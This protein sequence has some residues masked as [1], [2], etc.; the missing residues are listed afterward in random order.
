MGIPP[1]G[2]KGG[3]HFK[4]KGGFLVPGPIFLG[5]KKSRRKKEKGVPKKG[6]NSGKRKE[7]PRKF[8]ENVERKGKLTGASLTV[9]KRVGGMPEKETEFFGSSIK[10][11]GKMRPK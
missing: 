4:E 7:K 8:I 2:E 3:D 9:K 6:E 5:K 10:L 1:R 11:A